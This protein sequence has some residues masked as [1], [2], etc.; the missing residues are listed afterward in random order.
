M[1][2]APRYS[3]A[4]KRHPLRHRITGLAIACSA[5]FVTGVSLGAPAQAVGSVWDAVAACESGGHWAINTHNG[6]YGGLQFS[7]ATWKLFGGARYTLRPDRAS[8]GLQIAIARRV[9]VVQG[10]VAWP[11]CGKRA[12]LTRANGRAGA[13]YV[14][15]SRTRV[16]IA[17]HP[18]LAVDGRMGSRTIRALQHWVGTTQTGHLDSRTVK[19][20]QRRLG[21]RPVGVIGPRTVRAIQVRIGTRRDG[22]RHLNARTV[23]ALQ[24]FLN[25]H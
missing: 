23:A 17:F 12:G 10:P 3:A 2:Y 19:A 14:S 15:R 25:R 6:Y 22:A 7:A 9:L 21:M 24:R 18:R 11:A 5:T 16:A 13:L 8:R 1:Y 4:R 20:L